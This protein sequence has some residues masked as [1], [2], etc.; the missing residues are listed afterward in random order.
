V[1]ERS[2]LYRWL[3]SLS[4]LPDDDDLRRYVSIIGQAARLAAARYPGCRFDVLYWDIPG[5]A[6]PD[7]KVLAALRAAGLRVHDVAQILPDFRERP[8]SYALSAFDAHPGARANDLLARYLAR[9]LF[10]VTPAR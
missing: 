1:V 7:E 6:P 4:P 5:V 2:W 10:D 9:E 8:S 3:A